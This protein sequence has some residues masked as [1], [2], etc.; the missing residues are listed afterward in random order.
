M[1]P[2]ELWK[3]RTGRPEQLQFLVNREQI[4]ASV[5]VDLG[6]DLGRDL[7]RGVG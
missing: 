6:R 1:F 3:E 2:P 4:K 7:D 5:F